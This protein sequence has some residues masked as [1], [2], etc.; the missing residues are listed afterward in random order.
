M[1]TE[2]VNHNQCHMPLQK[3]QTWKRC[4]HTTIFPTSWIYFTGVLYLG[5]LLLSEINQISIYYGM[6]LLP[7]TENCGL[8]MRRECRERFPRHWLQR[9]PY[10]THVPWCMSGSLTRH[11]GENVPGIPGACATLNFT[12]MARGPWRSD[13]KC[14]GCNYLWDVITMS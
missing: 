11:G 6:G 7:D 13:Y 8:R 3:F 14:M 12:Y 5:S 9:R 4:N 2:T 10:V 1:V